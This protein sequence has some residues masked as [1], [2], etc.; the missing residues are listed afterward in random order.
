M[1]QFRIA[2]LLIT[3]LLMGCSVTP[4]PKPAA[5]PQATRMPLPTAASRG[6][7]SILADGQLVAGNPVLPVSF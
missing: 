6:G 1:K 3:V 7:G 4:T 2:S 5:T